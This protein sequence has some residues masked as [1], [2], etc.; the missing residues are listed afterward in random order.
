MKSCLRILS[1]SLALILL[2][3]SA[4]GATFRTR[5][6]NVLE[7]WE[8]ADEA[9]VAEGNV[10]MQK[11]N[12]A[13]SAARL[14]AIICEEADDGSYTRD[15]QGI[16]E[17]FE[18]DGAAANSALK[19]Q[20][21]GLYRCVEYLYVFTS[22][23]DARRTWRQ[24][25]KTVWS[26]YEYGDSQA[27]SSKGRTCQALDCIA[28]Y[29]Y[30]AACLCDADGEYS[31]NIDEA[32]DAYQ[33]RVGKDSLN[34]QIE[35]ASRTAVEFLYI[36]DRCMDEN[37]RYRTRTEEI[38]QRFDALNASASTQDQRIVNALYRFTE[39]L[40]VMGHQLAAGK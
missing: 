1:L 22:S 13:C 31:G 17:M 25:I 40:G 21:N 19:Q 36:A 30:I 24:S 39:L 32:W 34:A 35:N 26:N 6:S 15:I 3:S 27:R 38:M 4:L 16:G 20:V 37:N 9:C 8:K 7:D 2:T 18:E 33:E 29:C 23:L 14:L 11:A 28:E 10:E 5:V 12:G